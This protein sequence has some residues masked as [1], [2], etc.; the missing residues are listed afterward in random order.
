MTLFRNV[1]SLLL[2]VFLVMVSG[3]AAP[4]GAMVKHF[5]DQTIDDTHPRALLVLASDQLPGKVVITNVHFGTVGNFPRTQFSLQNLSKRKLALEYQIVWKDAEG[6]TVNAN[7]A[8]HRTILSPKQI[9]DVQ[10]VGKDPAAYQID[11]VLRLPDDLFIE[12]HR[13]EAQ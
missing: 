4:Q 12:S 3:C 9:Y 10:S 5:D 6:F 13:Q 11:V 8:W 2:I 1:S 7:N